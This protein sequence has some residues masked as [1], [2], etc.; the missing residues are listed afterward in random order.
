VPAACTLD[1]ARHRV[2]EIDSSGILGVMTLQ[3]ALQQQKQAMQQ[4]V[5]LTFAVDDDLLGL[6]VGVKVWGAGAAGGGG[7]R[8]RG[9][10]VAGATLAP[11]RRL[12]AGPDL[13]CLMLL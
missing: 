9:E 12:W 11:F 6:V 2:L 3:A 13:L 1:V 5:R 10:G 8:G 4:A 7:G